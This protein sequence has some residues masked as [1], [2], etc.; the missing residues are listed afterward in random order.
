MAQNPSHNNSGNNNNEDASRSSLPR[1]RKSPEESSKGDPGK[2]ENLGGPRARKDVAAANAR[3]GASRA[4]EP[5]VTESRETMTEFFVA[6]AS[7]QADVALD[8]SRLPA[9]GPKSKT[10]PARVATVSREVQTSK[11]TKD[12]HS[13]TQPTTPALYSMATQTDMQPAP[14]Y[15]FRTSTQKKQLAAF[16]SAFF[17]LVY[18]ILC[19]GLVCFA[20]DRYAE[21]F[22][23]EELDYF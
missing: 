16:I 10:E 19:Y 14:W 2:E 11:K 20:R 1:N 13:Q 3:E 18:L 23:Y 17:V 12:K 4:A 15:L 21:E 9:D 6:D 7:V 22:V 5:P 8:E